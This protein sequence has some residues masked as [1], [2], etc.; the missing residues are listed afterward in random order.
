[1][2]W[3]YFYL[4]KNIFFLLKSRS[5]VILHWFVDIFYRVLPLASRHLTMSSDF[6]VIHA[7]RACV[8]VRWLNFRPN[9]Y[10]FHNT[11]VRNELRYDRCA[12][13]VWFQILFSYFWVRRITLKFDDFY[14]PIFVDQQ[15]SILFKFHIYKLD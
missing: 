6:F 13:A 14:S 7:G 15:S 4:E 2:Q 1:M 11:N 3:L 9:P 5:F 10:Y 12:T 8:C